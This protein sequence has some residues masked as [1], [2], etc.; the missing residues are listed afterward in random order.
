[1]G[2]NEISA[3]QEKQPSEYPQAE[4]RKKK[5]EASNYKQSEGSEYD[6]AGVKYR[7]RDKEECYG[8]VEEIAKHSSQQSDRVSK[9]SSKRSV[10]NVELE[11]RDSL[12]DE[13][14]DIKREMKKGG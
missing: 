1:M 5:K 6:A 9:K 14:S 7:D 13:V 4:P 2:L 12:Q 10:N 11:E 3:I 8:L